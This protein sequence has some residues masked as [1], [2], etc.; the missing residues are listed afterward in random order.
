M[1]RRGAYF[2]L[3]LGGVT[4]IAAIIVACYDEPKPDCGFRCGPS[5][6]CPDDYTCGPDKRCRLNGTSPSLACGTIDAGTDAPADAEGSDAEGL[7][8]PRD[9]PLDAPPD[10]PLDAPSIDAPPD[11]FASVVAV[12]CPATPDAS[13]ITMNF[14]YV[15]ASVMIPVNGIVEF[16]IE[17][18]HDVVPDATN[19]DPGLNVP[20]GGNKCLRFTMAGTF[21]YHC[22]PHGFLGSVTVQ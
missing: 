3:A 13:V 9:A 5:G 4:A 7:D 19:S 16:T 18:G 10:T 21:G 2:G 6:A 20:N 1:S 8:G 14:M 11:A 15:P 17:A 22:G 12:T